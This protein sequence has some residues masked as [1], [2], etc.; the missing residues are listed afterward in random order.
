MDTAFSVE[1]QSNRIMQLRGEAIM[2]ASFLSAK[3]PTHIMEIGG[4]MGASFY[5]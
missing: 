5:V 1:I 2:M 4:F 3:R